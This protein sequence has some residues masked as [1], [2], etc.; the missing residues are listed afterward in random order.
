MSESLQSCSTV[1]LGKIFAILEGDTKVTALHFLGSV[2]ISVGLPGNQV[3]IARFRLYLLGY[4]YL[5][6]FP[7]STKYEIQ[8]VI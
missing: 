8:E 6:Y 4:R 3:P 7:T 5:A 2:L 1:M